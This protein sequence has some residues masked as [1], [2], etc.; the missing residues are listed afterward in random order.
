MYFRVIF[1]I[2]KI[3]FIK[4]N[5]FSKDFFL[6]AKGVQSFRIRIDTIISIPEMNVRKRQT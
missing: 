6:I 1:S 2:E 3:I 5:F 4:T